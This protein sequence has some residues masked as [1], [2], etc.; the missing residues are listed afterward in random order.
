MSSRSKELRKLGCA[1]LIWP[2]FFRGDTSLTPDDPGG[3]WFIMFK[4]NIT[5]LPIFTNR[6]M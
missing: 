6:L 1:K 2:F 3:G 5:L 4:V